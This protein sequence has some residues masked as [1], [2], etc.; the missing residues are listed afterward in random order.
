MT[1]QTLHTDTAAD[2][3]DTASAAEAPA[4]GR[5]AHIALW[6]LQVV[7]AGMYLMGSAVKLTASGGSA[8]A[9]AQIGF[10][11]WFLYFIGTCELLGGIALLIPRLAGLAGLAFVPMMIGATVVEAVVFGGGDVAAPIVALACVAT[12]AYARRRSTAELARLVRGRR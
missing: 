9:F 4:R 3:T 1:A 7:T 10:G 12:I 2:T 11:G 6:T 5:K 8:E